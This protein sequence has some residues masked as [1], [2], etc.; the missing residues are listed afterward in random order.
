MSNLYKVVTLC[1]ST[2]FKEEFYKAQAGLTLQ[3]YIVISVGLF[4]HADSLYGNVITEEVK[5]LLDDMYRSKIDMS[6]CIY[7]INKDGYIGE[8]TKSEI[9]YAIRNGKDVFYLE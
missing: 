5:V 6:D 9:E 4:G 3:G 2:K 1:G 7:V 8:S